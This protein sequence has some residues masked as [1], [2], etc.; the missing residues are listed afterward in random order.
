MKEDTIYK[1]SQ[2][3]ENQMR[4]KRKSNKAVAYKN[5]VSEL[6]KFDYKDIPIRNSMLRFK[7]KYEEIRRANP[8]ITSM[9]AFLAMISEMVVT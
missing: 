8:K 7:T 5:I 9:D 3:K 6:K 1:S 2:K 4:S